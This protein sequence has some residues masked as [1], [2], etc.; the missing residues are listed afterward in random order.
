MINMS[1]DINSTGDSLTPH[2]G[3][4]FSTI[5]KDNDVHNSNCA[6]VYKGAWWYKSCHES[7][8]NGQYLNG[9]HKSFA[10]GV[11]WKR[12]KGYHYSLKSVELMVAPEA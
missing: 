6:A 11:N 1:I 9:T 5:D 7:N 12:W 10:D 8:L 4:S 3:Q 2:N